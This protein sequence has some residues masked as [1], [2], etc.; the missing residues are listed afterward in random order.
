MTEILTILQCTV[1]MNE[2]IFLYGILSNISKELNILEKNYWG[3]KSYATFRLVYI[4]IPFTYISILSTKMNYS[5]LEPS[6]PSHRN[7]T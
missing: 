2:C 1:I 5:A 6:K 7:P 3:M 4:I